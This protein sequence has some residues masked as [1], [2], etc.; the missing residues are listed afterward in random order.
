MF[1][2]FSAIY[3]T[4]GRVNTVQILTLGSNF[5]LLCIIIESLYPLLA[6]RIS[7]WIA[8]SMLRTRIQYWLRGVVYIT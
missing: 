1:C 5:I 8:G 6:V 3:C 4:I 7:D 2:A